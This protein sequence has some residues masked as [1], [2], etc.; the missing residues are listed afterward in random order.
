MKPWGL[1]AA[2]LLALPCAL[3]FAGHASIER[4]M[5]EAER[6]ELQRLERQV[7][8]GAEATRQAIERVLDHVTTLGLL[9]QV[10]RRYQLGDD[11]AQGEP[12]KRHI[13]ELTRDQR[14]PVLQLALIG[15]DGFLEWSSV[16]GSE[17]MDLNDRE[18]FR[19]HAEGL[20]SPFIS[21]PLVGRASGRWSVQA[22][23][24]I[25]REDGGFV[26]VVVISLDPAVISDTLDTLR[27][28]RDGV[29]AL[30][31]DDGIFIARSAPEPFAFGMRVRPDNLEVLTARPSGTRLV[32]RSLD[33]TEIMLGWERVEGWPLIATY[34]I[35][36]VALREA[37][38]HRRADLRLALAGAILGLGA[39]AVSVALVVARRKARRALAEAEA[40]RARALALIASLPGAAYVATIRP[41][42]TVAEMQPTEALSF[43]LGQPA[44]SPDWT[45]RLEAAA[46]EAR[47]QAARLALVRG[48][49][50]AE[51]RLVAAD[52]RPLWVR[53]HLRA[54]G[55]GTPL[56][57]EVV[58]LLIDVSEQRDATA[59]ALTAA[60]L[61]TLGEMATGVAHEINQPAA[62]IA[63]AAD[64]T[65]LRLEQGPG[66]MPGAL[67]ALRSI[68]EQAERIR[69]IIRQVQLFGRGDDS[70][71][72]LERVLLPRALE[73]ALVLVGGALVQGSVR[74]EVDVPANL[75]PLRA[76]RIAIEQ[77]LVNLLLNARDALQSEPVE[78]RCVRVSAFEDAASGLVEVA[79]SDTGPG[80]PAE[81]LPRLF[82][83]FVT[84]K[85]LGQG[86][87][88]G[89]A[90]VYGIVHGFGG[91]IQACNGPERGATL[92]I[93]L[94]AWAEVTA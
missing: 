70:S 92:R 78:A 64:V 1:F 84:S 29:S 55:R 58:G 4:I 53:D 81:I 40:E 9:G 51:Y 69:E 87:G 17:R 23:R 91:H 14:Q 65:H 41:D 28:S 16:P 34:G 80:I 26:G 66:G 63:L 77:V 60:K 88:L 85:P 21:A 35:P 50:M 10:V 68:A 31:R 89:L 86:T 27:A 5:A 38:A 72:P 44:D 11:P 93:T 71:A 73:G 32:T 13:Q 33:G 48:A 39:V 25:E 56:G 61:A 7:M 52:R 76:R 15:A 19:V 24:R 75:P 30:I 54:T 45:G 83:P 12:L 6:T 79:V 59:Q 20:R 3:G 74:L 18:H 82:E 2:A 67:A 37:L 43:L 57:Q 49:A 46:R 94:P 90:I 62:A 47:A 8:S 36:V 22:T 42:G